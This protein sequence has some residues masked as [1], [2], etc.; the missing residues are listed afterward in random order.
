MLGVLSALQPL[1]WPLV[2]L[3]LRWSLFLEGKA[4]QGFVSPKLQKSLLPPYEPCL[5]PGMEL[6][7]HSVVSMDRT[8]FKIRQEGL[9]PAPV[10]KG[11]PGLLPPSTEFRGTRGMRPSGACVL[12]LLKVLTLDTW[13]SRMYCPVA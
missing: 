5:R 9:A 4:R 6:E 13:D 8:A 2:S 11:A 10:L 3:I 12:L 7:F 1:C